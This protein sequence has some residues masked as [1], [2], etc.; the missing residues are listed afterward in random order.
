MLNYAQVNKVFSV[1]YSKNNLLNA[2]VFTTGHRHDGP[3]VQ[4]GKQRVEFLAE[5]PREGVDVWFI[6]HV[7]ER[8]LAL[9]VIDVYS[10][11]PGH[12]RGWQRRLGFRA[13]VELSCAP[14]QS[15]V[16]LRGLHGEAAVPIGGRRGDSDSPVAVVC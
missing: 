16:T 13:G 6:L 3:S 4:W 12:L 7:V 8:D 2:V 9:F 15:P 10:H 14:P 5:M 1:T 11:L